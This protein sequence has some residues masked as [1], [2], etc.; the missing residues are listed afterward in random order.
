AAVIEARLGPDQADVHASRE[1]RADARVVEVEDARVVL[2]L[3]V[4]ELA[5][6]GRAV[7]ATLEAL[8]RTD[9]AVRLHQ[10]ARVE[11]RVLPRAHE[12]RPAEVRT[13]RRDQQPA[14]PQ[15]EAGVR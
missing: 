3:R 10:W 1:Q 11:A 13:I 7:V 8:F 4:Q 12:P 6:H 14:C 15:V 2:E 5:P 9:R